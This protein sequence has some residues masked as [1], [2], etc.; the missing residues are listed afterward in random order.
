MV[1]VGLAVVAA[2]ILLTVSG[3]YFLL[4]REKLAREGRHQELNDDV[5]KP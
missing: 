2:V 3:T 5:V 1:Y 4:R